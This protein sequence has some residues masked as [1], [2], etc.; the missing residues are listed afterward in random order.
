[1]S[2]VLSSVYNKVQVWFHLPDI[3]ITYYVT[4]LV[5]QVSDEHMKHLLQS[6]HHDHHQERTLWEETTASIQRLSDQVL[7]LYEESYC[8]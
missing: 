6:H 3:N 5:T 8:Y 1:M 4:E 7:F 2:S